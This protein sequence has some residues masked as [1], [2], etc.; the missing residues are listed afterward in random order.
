MAWLMLNTSPSHHSRRL[1]QR[2]GQ[3]GLLSGAE[4][5]EKAL[6]AE[7]SNF[8]VFAKREKFWHSATLA[9]HIAVPHSRASRTGG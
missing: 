3:E 1:G 6:E 9:S 8:I 7:R 2:T 4:R 5:A